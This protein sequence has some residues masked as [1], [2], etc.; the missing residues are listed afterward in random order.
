MLV[1]SQSKLKQIALK[2]AFQLF[3]RSYQFDTDVSL[4]FFRRI[5]K[6]QKSTLRNKGCS[7]QIYEKWTEK[8]HVSTWI[9]R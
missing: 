2:Q 4:H 1:K 7:Y 9:I 3:L 5:K 8:K 6:R